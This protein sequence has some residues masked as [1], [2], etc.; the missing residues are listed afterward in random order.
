M[1]VYDL[2]GQQQ[3]ADWVAEHYGPVFVQSSSDKYRVAELREA[4]GEPLLTVTVPGDT[5]R[6]ECYFFGYKI[7]F[8]GTWG[9]LTGY[10]DSAGMVT[11]PLPLE[12]TYNV[13][14]QGTHW[15]L[16]DNLR[17]IG[18]G[19]PDNSPRWRHLDVVLKEAIGR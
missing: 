18:L 9:R 19:V 17:L 1:I 4:E 13:A 14:G 16:A 7:G 10:P 6:I 11:F 2:S 5:T 3:N 12:F 8:E 15:L